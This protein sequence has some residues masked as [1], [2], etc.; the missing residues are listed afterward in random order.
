MNIDKEL[1][2]ADDQLKSVK[3]AHFITDQ[4]FPDSA[5]EQFEACLPGHNDFFIAGP[6]RQLHHIRKTPVKFVSQYCFLNPFFKRKMTQYDLIVVHALTTF[7]RCL[8]EFI[9]KSNMNII[10][11]GMGYDYYDLMIDD[12]HELLCAKTKRFYETLSDYQQTKPSFRARCKRSIEKRIWGLLKKITPKSRVIEKINF[13]APVLKSEYN[14]LKIKHRHKLP[15]FVDWNYSKSAGLIDQLAQKGRIVINNNAILLG[16]SADPTN[17]HIDMIDWLIAQTRRQIIC[18]LNY[19]EKQYAEYLVAYASKYLGSQFVPITEF[20]Q[21]ETYIGFINN[22]STVIMNHRRQQAGGNIAIMLVKG[23][24]VFL[25]SEN[26]FYE[27]YKNLGAV[28]FSIEE[29][30]DQPSLLTY[31]LTTK[32][33]KMNQK[34]VQSF[35]GCDAALQ[36][37]KMLLETCLVY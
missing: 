13:F 32:Q 25:R 37:T 30:L 26:P 33:V 8:V 11:I 21:Y 5:Y 36:R 19:G 18:P 15:R 29:L 34:I 6:K 28:I 4:K 10:W 17:N 23:A 3:I 7:H 2:I 35:L 14:M 16:N 1:N 12:Q 20:L 9:N 27:H 24:T 31:R 22:C